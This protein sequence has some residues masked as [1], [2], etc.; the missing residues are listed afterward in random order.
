MDLLRPSSLGEAL[1]DRV[2]SGAGGGCARVIDELGDRLPGL[3]AL[4]GNQCRC[5]GCERILDAVRTAAE[6]L[7]DPA[8]KGG[9]G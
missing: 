5:T 6:R 7:E 3:E 1:E 4:A 2:R 9:R 8:M